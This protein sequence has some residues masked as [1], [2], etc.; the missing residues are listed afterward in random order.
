MSFVGKTEE[1]LIKTTQGK[2]YKL[3]LLEQENGYW[4]ALVLYA[5]NGTVSTHKEVDVD[6]SEAYRRACEFA[7]NNIDPQ[8]AIDPL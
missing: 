5:I 2:T 3:F 1:K 8:A 7:L 4:L 6:K